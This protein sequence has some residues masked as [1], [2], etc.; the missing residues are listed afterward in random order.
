MYTENVLVAE[1]GR[2][3]GLCIK[4]L[5]APLA[6]LPHPHSPAQGLSRLCEQHPLELPSEQMTLRGTILEPLPLFLGVWS[7]LV[8][9]FYFTFPDHTPHLPIPPPS[10]HTLTSYF[11]VPLPSPGSEP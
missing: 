7:P 9:R 10:T 11:M 6:P 1:A 4:Q 3:L 5:P 8:S 2:I